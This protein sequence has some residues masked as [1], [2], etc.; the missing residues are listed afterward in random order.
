MKKQLIKKLVLN[1]E[2][3]HD[4]TNNEMNVIRGASFIDACT[5]SCSFIEVCCGPTTKAQIINFDQEPG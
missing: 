4:L 5:E 3:I 2:T 1:K